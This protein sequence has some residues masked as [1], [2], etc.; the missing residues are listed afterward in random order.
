MID[1]HSKLKP[2]KPTIITSD[3]EVIS[4]FNK[5]DPYAVVPNLIE[6]EYVLIEDYYTNGLVVLE[7]LKKSLKKKI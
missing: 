5:T 1:N 6:G 3:L 2:D 7:A 4:F